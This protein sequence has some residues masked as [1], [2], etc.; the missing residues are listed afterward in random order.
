MSNSALYGGYT[1]ATSQYQTRT[2]FSQTMGY[3]ALAA[4]LF[5]AGAYVGRDMSYGL[6]FVW[7]IAAFACLIAMN[8]A[9]RRSLPALAQVQGRQVGAA[10]GRVDLPRC[11]ERVPVLPADLRAQ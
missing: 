8:F 2:L 4:A 11:A 10:A 6:G 3:V 1:G 9:V 7:F 5:A